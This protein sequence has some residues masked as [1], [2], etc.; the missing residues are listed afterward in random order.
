MP[1]VDLGQLIASPLVN[2]PVFRSMLLEALRD[3]APFGTAT[4]G[5]IGM[6][7]VETESGFSMSRTA[8]GDDRDKPGKDIPVPIRVCDVYAWMLATLEGAPAFNPC[9]P[10]AKRDAGV[11]AVADF[12]KSKGPRP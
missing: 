11:A 3:R 7:R 10:E 4:L 2:V 1:K 8:P 6:V 12:M 5:E 9:W